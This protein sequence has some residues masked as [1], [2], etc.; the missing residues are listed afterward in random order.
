MVRPLRTI[1]TSTHRITLNPVTVLMVTDN[2][3]GWLYTTYDVYHNFAHIGS[4]INR[5]TGQLISMI[6]NHEV[7]K[8]IQVGYTGRKTQIV[9]E[10]ELLDMDVLLIRNM[11]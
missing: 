5:P 7:D 10:A 3:V 6:Q 4:A 8:V 2:A 9:Q 11:E 1:V